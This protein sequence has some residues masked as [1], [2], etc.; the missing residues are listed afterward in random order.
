ME[1]NKNER[2]FTVL[3]PKFF[4]RQ[5]MNDLIQYKTIKKIGLL[6]L[7]SFVGNTVVF[8][9]GDLPVYGKREIEEFDD[10]EFTGEG[11]FSPSGRYLALVSW[12]PDEKDSDAEGTWKVSV[13]EVAT[14]ECTATLVCLQNVV[15]IVF[16]PCDESILVTAHEGGV[17]NIWK[18]NDANKEYTNVAE[19]NGVEDEITGTFMRRPKVRFSTDGSLLIAS[20]SWFGYQVRIWDMNVVAQDGVRLMPVYVINHVVAEKDFSCCGVESFFLKQRAG[21]YFLITASAYNVCIWDMRSGECVKTFSCDYF[22]QKDELIKVA[23]LIENDGIPF[24][25]LVGYN[26]DVVWHCLNDGEATKTVTHIGNTCIGPVQDNSREQ[27]DKLILMN[28]WDKS[29]KPVLVTTQG[30]TVRIWDVIHQ[31]PCAIQNSEELGGVEGCF[32]IKG[33]EG[34]S[35][36][37]VS[38]NGDCVVLNG[39]SLQVCICDQYGSKYHQKAL[40]PYGPFQNVMVSPDSQYIAAIGYVNVLLWKIRREREWAEERKIAFMLA[41]HPRT[42]AASVARVLPQGLARHICNLVNQE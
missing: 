41:F 28:N 10:G 24:C 14:G 6:L 37:T 9:V 15:D 29:A 35:K 27:R 39:S 38:A 26:G 19:L 7:L 40:Y 12:L 23:N 30:D 36:G 20:N 21:H 5:N 34:I 33:I 2:N 3:S 17:I 42:G 16:H 22:E 13:H 32:S 25:I 11:T 1:V 8:S 31:A 18:F 4:E